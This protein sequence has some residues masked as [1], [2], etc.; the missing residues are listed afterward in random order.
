MEVAAD[1]AESARAG[2][3]GLRVHVTLDGHK[4]LGT[5]SNGLSMSKL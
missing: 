3:Y 4:Q 5:V 1:T 2:G